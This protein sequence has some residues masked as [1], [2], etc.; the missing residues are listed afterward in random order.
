MKL[1]FVLILLFLA[2]PA[3]AGNVVLLS[4]IKL[5]KL[6]Y[7]RMESRF[8]RA[9]QDS[10]RKIIIY[11]KTSPELLHQILSDE[12]SEIII[13]VSHA[14]AVN[15]DVPGMATKGIISDFYGNDVKN[16]FTTPKNNLKFLGIVGCSAKSIFDGF[17]ERGHF[18]QLPNLEIHTFDK[19]VYLLD[20]L[21]KTLTLAKSHLER[22]LVLNTE[23][24]EVDS[25]IVVDIENEF[26]P[27]GFSWLEFA[28]RIYPL[29]DRIEI[30]QG[31]WI[32]N[33]NKNLRHVKDLSSDGPLAKLQLKSDQ[34]SWRLF[35]T[36]D[37]NPIG[38]LNKHLYIFK[39]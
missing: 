12:N 27:T 38:A 35:T 5:S 6:A 8:K 3:F 2:L 18:S 21:Q 4:S 31:D 22:E 32:K 29:K 16:F 34:G 24:E 23:E 30:N 28:D 26:L 1:F 37:G 25:S 10:G 14:A 11:R 39:P 7:F 20:G 17:R 19:N 36:K 9:F 33:P 13:W 15:N